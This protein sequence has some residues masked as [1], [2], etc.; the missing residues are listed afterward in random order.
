MNIISN[1][2]KGLLI[3]IGAIAPGV[4]GGAL[5]VIFGVFE[6]L[7]DA[8]AN[9]FSDIQNKMKFLLPLGLGGGLGVLAFSNIMKYLFQYYEV[10]IKYLFIGFMIGTF[11]S[12]LRE[13]NK[14]GFRI[15]YLIPLISAFTITL[16]ISIVENKAFSIIAETKPTIVELV[17]YGAIIGFGTI[18]PGI[19]ASFIL[20]YIGVYDFLLE[21]ISKIDLSVILPAGIGV[22]LS[23]IK[24]ANLIT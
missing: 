8:I 16:L 19:S 24:F 5:A 7:N 23:V 10:E 22:I 17:V 13:A 15:K 1:F 11:P 12:V 21:A 4:S 18:V 14:H 20:M 2:I 3:G 9:P 6:K